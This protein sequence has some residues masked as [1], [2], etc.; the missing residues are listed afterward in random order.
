MRGNNSGQ[1]TGTAGSPQQT[2]DQS[3][4]ANQEAAN[5]RDLAE[6][7]RKERL[8]PQSNIDD[9][10]IDLAREF[11]MTS[12]GYF[13]R[14]GNGKGVRVI[15]CDNP[16]TIAEYCYQ[17]LGQGGVETIA[18]NRKGQ[19]IHMIRLGDGSLVTYRQITSSKGSPAVEIRV[20]SGLHIVKQ[21]KIHYILKETS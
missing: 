13:G 18:T 15:D 7:V 20:S 14:K 16:V 10:A 1:T 2:I 5:E 11:H 19:T 4:Y 6:R 17:V 3:V 9:N 21:Q 8:N 12:A